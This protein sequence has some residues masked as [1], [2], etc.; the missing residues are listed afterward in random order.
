MKKEKKQYVKLRREILNSKTIDLVSI[1]QLRN[2]Q[3]KKSFDWKPQGGWREIA[4]KSV[5][6]EKYWVDVYNLL[7]LVV[8]S[9]A[10]ISHHFSS[11]KPKIIQE[12]SALTAT[13]FLN[14]IIPLFIEGYAEL[15]PRVGAY[16]KTN[17][18][19]RFN[20]EIA[21]GVVDSYGKEGV[22]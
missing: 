15:F 4:Q 8:H 18:S 6:S 7:S 13:S 2:L 11:K 3:Q 9:N 12:T 20:I 16:L 17:S 21:K 19:L 10:V 22:V 1:K 14:Y 5:L